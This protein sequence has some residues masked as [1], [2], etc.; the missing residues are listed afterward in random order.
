MIIKQIWI[1]VAIVN[2]TALSMRAEEPQTKDAHVAKCPLMPGHTAPAAMDGCPLM[3]GHAAGV[4]ER[5]DKAMGF[6]HDKTTH[7]FRVLADGGAIEVEANDSADK[8]SRDEI[9]KHLALITQMFAAGDFK[10]PVQVHAKTPRGASTMEQLKDKIRYRYENT[11]KGGRV[12]LTTNDPEALKAV[13]EFM[14]F[15]I[16]EHTTG[17]TMEIEKRP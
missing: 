7:H 4:D 14:R 1:A 8:K 6:S 12:R 10:I 11:E 5:G 13:H 15:Q 16:E 2:M 9:R 3:G 17:D